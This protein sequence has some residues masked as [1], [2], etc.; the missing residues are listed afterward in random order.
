MHLCLWAPKATTSPA[1]SI[2]MKL[3]I[4]CLQERIKTHI[5]CLLYFYPRTVG[6]VETSCVVLVRTN[7]LCSTTFYCICILLF[8]EDPRFLAEQSI[9]VW[10]RMSLLSLKGILCHFQVTFN[11]TTKTLKFLNGAQF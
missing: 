7:S 1:I 5:L 11:N 2:C 6:S 8:P 3:I 4:F 9:A 10:Q